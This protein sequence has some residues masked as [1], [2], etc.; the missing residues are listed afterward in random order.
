MTSG[1]NIP[2]M[3]SLRRASCK[4]EENISSPLTRGALLRGQKC[5]LPS[6]IFPCLRGGSLRLVF[7][8]FAE[9]RQ[10]S[11]KRE[12]ESMAERHHSFERPTSTLAFIIAYQ[13][14][15]TALPLWTLDQMQGLGAVCVD[16]DQERGNS[17][18]WESTYDLRVRKESLVPVLEKKSAST[19]HKRK[20]SGKKRSQE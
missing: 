13:N 18:R 12:E 6:H 19:I 10:V 14:L 2:F 1:W 4:A 16:L 9:W 17:K 15:C 3:S 7:I 11:L 20:M 5:A 8:S